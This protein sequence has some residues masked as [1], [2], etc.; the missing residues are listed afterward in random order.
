M[1]VL[2]HHAPALLFALAA[3]MVAHAQTAPQ[4]SDAPAAEPARAPAADRPAAAPAAPPRLIVAISVDQFAAD[5]F[6]QYRP[7]FTGGL[8]RMA[9]GVVFPSGYQAHAA[10]ETCPG[11]STILTGAL[12]YRSGIIANNWTDLN[13][14]RADKSV[15]CAEDETAPGSTSS[16]YTVSAVHLKVPVLGERLKAAN[17]RSR[18]VAVAGKDRAAV[19][20]GGGRTDQSWWWDGKQF[21]TFKGRATLPVVD[22]TNAAVARLIAQGQ[23]PLDLPPACARVDQPIAIGG[24]NSVGTGRFQRAPGD[25]RGFRA[26]PALDGA[27][28]ALAAGLVQDMGLGKGEATDILAVGVS[29]TDYVGHTFGNQGTEM[30]LQLMSLDEDLGQFFAVLDAAGID[31]L[32]VLT[33]DHGG[34]DLPERI[35]IQGAAD[36][37]RLDPALA[38]A[39]MGKAIAGELGLT[40]QLMWGGAGGD[41]W[42]DPALS[43][44]DRRRVVDAA[45]RRYAAHE[46]VET[47]FTRAQI[48]ATALP[49]Q[50]SPDAWTLIERARAA[51]DPARAGDFVVVLKQRVTPIP[52]A[53]RGYVATHGSIWDYDRRV[54]ILFWRKGMAGFE[55]PLAIS[56]TDI[57][58][59]LAGVLKLPL[60]AN[61]IDGQCRDLDVTTAS[62]CP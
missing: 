36:A 40:G 39:T 56:T 32:A 34:H 50:R 15:Y 51:F 42:I 31:Y 25:A 21:A 9:S 13:A 28:L 58:P 4:K 16:D 38:P 6:A 60:P 45:V 24:G 52:D 29:A 12:P 41:V 22:R 35:R 37:T 18:N 19:M 20:M 8:A 10:T 47:V 62:T 30:C 49:R 27:T 11:H 17:P 5:L 55:Q 53:S 14:A 48:L 43:P 2:R 54:P 23:P 3:P 1:R 7:H 46:Q 33:A 44:A 26:S 57:A 61:E 59:T